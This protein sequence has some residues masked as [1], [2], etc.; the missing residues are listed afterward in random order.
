MVDFVNVYSEYTG[1]GVYVRKVFFLKYSMQ[2]HYKLISMAHSRMST[3]WNKIRNTQ[4]SNF[5]E[6]FQHC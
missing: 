3:S 5:S 2:N 6:I 4:K 1:R